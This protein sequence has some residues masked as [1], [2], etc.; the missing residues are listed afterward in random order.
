MHRVL[1]PGGICLVSVPF[2]NLLKKLMLPK[3]LQEAGRPARFYQYV[4]T[5]E[6]ILR[7][8]RE[9]GFDIVDVRLV[10]RNVG[11][12]HRSNW[13]R[14]MARRPGYSGLHRRRSPV[15]IAYDVILTILPKGLSGHMIRI[16]VKVTP[17]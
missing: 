6:A 7:T 11:I 1:V 9:N 3:R 13:L 2:M 12:E 4:F 14:Q 17:M 8:L 10:G 5:E 16:K 15:R